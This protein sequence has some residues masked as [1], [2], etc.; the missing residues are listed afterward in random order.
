VPLG[1]VGL[2]C[3]SGFST[4]YIVIGPAVA[5]GAACQFT[6]IAPRYVF[7]KR[8]SAGRSGWPVRPRVRERDDRVAHRRGWR[9]AELRSLM[10]H[11]REGVLLAVRQGTVR[12]SSSSSW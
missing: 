3:R 11:Y 10:G 5:F 1:Y 8:G 4:W 2:R 7:V 9:L 12:D 6:W